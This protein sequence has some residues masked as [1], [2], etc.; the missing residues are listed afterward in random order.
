MIT[1]SESESEWFDMRVAE[2]I[3]TVSSHIEYARRLYWC[4]WNKHFASFWFGYIISYFYYASSSIWVFASLF[5]I[6]GLKYLE[7][8]PKCPWRMSRHSTIILVPVCHYQWFGYQLSS[9]SLICGWIMEIE[10]EEPKRSMLTNIKNLIVLMIVKSI[11]MQ[12]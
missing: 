11:Q 1:E 12:Q 2:D 10:M 5:A 7:E 8:R 4:F 9:D 6:L 3:S